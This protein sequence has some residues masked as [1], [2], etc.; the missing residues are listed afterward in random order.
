MFVRIGYLVTTRSR[1]V[2]VVAG[3]LL[4]LAAA[5]GIRAPGR[6]LGGGFVSAHAPSQVASNLLDADFRAT[7]NLTFLVT[8]RNGTVDSPQVASAGE[9]LTA[10]LVRQPGVARVTSY[11]ATHQRALRSN[12]GREALVVVDV[13]GTDS[14][15]ASRT[16]ALLHFT[17]GPAS[18]GPVTVQAGDTAAVNHAIT[19]QIGKDLGKAEGLAVPITMLL[20]L[21]AFGSL[22]AAALPLVTGVCSIFGTLAVL[23][24]L[25]QF[26]N[27]STYA[28]NL[29]TA[30][31]LGLGIDSALLIVNRYREE[32]AG[33]LEPSAAVRRTVE[34][35]GRTVAFSGAA[36]AA[37]MATLLV[38][39]ITFLRSFAYAGV[40]VA[41]ISAVAAVVV[42]PSVLT[43]L[44]HRVNAVPIRRRALG[45]PAE[46]A[47]WRRVA[48]A[49]M[50]R[51]VASA[52]PVLILLLAVGVPFLHVSFG[53]PDD[54]V[55]PAS[56]QPRQVDNVVRSQF[57][58]NANNT[59]DVVT[60]SP[61]STEAAADYSAALSRLPGVSAVQG[62]A[63]VYDNGRPVV[64][65]GVDAARYQ[66]PDGSW[67]SATVAPD[68]LSSQA[69]SLVRQARALPSSPG[70]TT[71]VGGQAASFLDQKHDLS[72]SL[73]L[74]IG[75]IVL[76][77]FA[78]LFLYT[79]SVVLPLKALVLNALN[80]SAVFGVMVWV[81]QDGHLSG[82]LGFTPTPTNTAMPVLLFCLAFGLSMDYEV[83]LLSRIKELHDEGMPNEEAVAGGLARTGRIMTTAAGIL[84]VSFFAFGLSSISFMQLFGIG[85]GI[86][87]LVDAT[88]VRGVLV[89]A[90]MRI[91]GDANWWAPPALRR[92]H[93]RFGLSEAAPV[94]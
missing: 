46:S 89:P 68:A 15:V 22:V 31:G 10:T 20:L 63:G 41:V 53:P 50:R 90:F 81:F 48:T 13:A 70:T 44:G 93:R 67:F 77:T 36:I 7:P 82:L 1:Q 79:G 91:A 85:T 71:Y 64:G 72:S 30:M 74:A 88:L 83:F 14:Q 84:A 80:L 60:T 35:A 75:L 8:A 47:F 86:A 40:S 54:R 73:P 23:F 17:V 59:L 38:F 65:A 12:G 58:T 11:W 21:L 57:P 34:T 32:L 49:V 62:P 33:G 26:V 28:L 39:P 78:V 5:F 29:T 2:L 19:G 94:S 92:L 52:L 16:K 42:L 43:L 25:S 61:V 18:A 3:M 6:L 87:I 55:L 37:A 69:A 51:P 27:V 9:A 76:L 4:L 56:A 24:V 66:S 45:R